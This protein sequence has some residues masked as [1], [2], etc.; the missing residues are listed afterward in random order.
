MSMFHD[1]KLNMNSKLYFLRSL[2]LRNDCDTVVLVTINYGIF[3]RDCNLAKYSQTCKS[4]S[5]IGRMVILY[6]E[7]N[8]ILYIGYR[9]PWNIFKL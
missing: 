8:K 4:N 9:T 7:Y 5:A 1:K 2:L 6:G 3:I